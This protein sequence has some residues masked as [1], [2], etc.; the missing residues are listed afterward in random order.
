[1]AMHI[2]N[3]HVQ[4]VD[5]GT[6]RISAGQT[7]VTVTTEPQLANDSF[8]V[9]KKDK[10]THVPFWAAPSTTTA[11]KISIDVAGLVDNNFYWAVLR[12]V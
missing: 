3:P 12:E 2:Q 11:L 10:G 5:C 1:M 8:S 4:V 9:L 6:A 7:S